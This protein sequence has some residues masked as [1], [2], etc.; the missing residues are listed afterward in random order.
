MRV[1]FHGITDDIGYFIVA[2]VFEFTHGVQNPALHWLEA[3]VGVGYCALKYNVAGVVEKPLAKHIVDVARVGLHLED[4]V[5][6]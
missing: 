6:F 1:I 4:V 3:I 2:S 5:G